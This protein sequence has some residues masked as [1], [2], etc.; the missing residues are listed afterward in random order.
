MNPKINLGTAIFT[1]ALIV[2]FATVIVE[3]SANYIKR[4]NV[5]TA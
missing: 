3:T 5:N 1:F 2:G 4:R